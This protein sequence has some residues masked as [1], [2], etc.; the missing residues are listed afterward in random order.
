MAPAS[1]PVACRPAVF[2]YHGRMS[3]YVAVETLQ[4]ELLPLIDPWIVPTPFLAQA[5]RGPALEKPYH[6]RRICSERNRFYYF[7]LPAVWVDVLP[8]TALAYRVLHD[9]WDLTA[10]LV[11]AVLCLLPAAA[12]LAYFINRREWANHYRWTYYALSR[13]SLALRVADPEFW[14]VFLY[15]EEGAPGKRFD[16]VPTT[17]WALLRLATFELGSLRAYARQEDGGLLEQA[18]GSPRLAGGLPGRYT[19]TNARYAAIYDFFF[20]QQDEFQA[21]L[22]RAEA[23]EEKQL[24]RLEVGPIG[25]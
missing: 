17:L 1:A 3:P 16:A 12:S 9:G 10:R 6:V 15:P 5:Q 25:I 11:L 18:L 4:L 22:R 14:R 21:A 23:E 13:K 2:G 19:R 8:A 7:A 20:E 24:R